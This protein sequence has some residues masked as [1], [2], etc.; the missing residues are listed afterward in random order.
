MVV[1]TATL[2]TGRLDL[3]TIVRAPGETYANLPPLAGLR[4]LTHGSFWKSELYRPPRRQ[5]SRQQRRR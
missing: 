3:E 4:P 1:G 2:Q 5:G